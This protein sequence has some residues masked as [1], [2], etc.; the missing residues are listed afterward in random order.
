MRRRALLGSVGAVALAGCSTDGESTTATP[1][2]SST[3]PNTGTGTANF[4]LV[5][6]EFPETRALNVP[7]VFGIAIRNTGSAKGTFTS[8]LETKV[9]DGEWKKAGTLEMPLAAGETGEWHSPRFVPQYLTTLYY[10]LAAFDETWSIKITPRRLDFSNYYA[11]PN[12]L[13]INVLGGSFESGSTDGSTTATETATMPAPPDGKT[14]LVMRVDVRNS[15]DESQSAPDA[16][17][18][19]LTVDGESRSLH[20]NVT[21]DP[22]RGG[23]L[24]AKTVRRGNLVYAVPTG[25]TAND[26]TMSWSASLP[27]GD[28]KAIWTK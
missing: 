4:E 19:T 8:A 28:V 6:A 1:T 18:F 25:T 12:G 16:S 9:G 23:S 24:D 17:T 11:V 7:T 13:Y 14:W 26:I 22:Y 5:T 27:E 2:P 21:D 20:R 3:P 15:L 10:R